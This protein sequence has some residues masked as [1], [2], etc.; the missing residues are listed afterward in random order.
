MTMKLVYRNVLRTVLCSGLLLGAGVL[1]SAL[2]PTSQKASPA[3]EDTK[4]NEQDRSQTEPTAD[5]QKDNRSDQDITQ[6]IRKSITKDKS[7]STYAHNVKIITQ[8]GQ[9]TLKGPVRSE[10]EKRMV[11]AKATEVAG[12]SKV[13]SELNIKPQQ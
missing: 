12:E 3:A 5:Q 8:H 4:V 2:E 7:L 10:D 13:S 9:V 11:E 6:Q 1:A